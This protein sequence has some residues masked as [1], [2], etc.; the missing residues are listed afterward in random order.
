M[1]ASIKKNKMG[2]FFSKKKPLSYEDDMAN[3]INDDTKFNIKEAYKTTRTNVIF[4]LNSN[5][6]CKRIIVTSSIPGEG[7]SLTSVNTAITFAMANTKVLII[8]CDLRKPKLH[9]YLGVDNKKGLSNVLGGFDSLEDCLKRNKDLNIDFITAGHTPPNPIE[10]L[11]SENMSKLLDEMSEKYDYIFL[12]TPPVNVVADTSAIAKFVDGI[13]FV[14]RHK[15]TTQDMV[16]KAISSMEFANAK[17]LGF[18]LNDVDL[19]SYSFTSKVGYGNY[20]YK[21]YYQ[22]SSYYY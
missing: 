18:I 21:N 19:S 9:R 4:S 6:G 3:I 20:K 12:D 16:Y 2:G 10:L 5:K 7:K 15:F 11:S 13:L 14:V 17:V 22:Y 8:D 1:S